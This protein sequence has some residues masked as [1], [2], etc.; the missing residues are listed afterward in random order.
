MNWDNTF[1]WTLDV[2]P[3]LF[4]MNPFSFYLDEAL[5]D[6]E[7]MASKR[8]LKEKNKLIFCYTMPTISQQ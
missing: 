3:T 8:V 2:S 7:F 5:M 1:V 6:K 4:H